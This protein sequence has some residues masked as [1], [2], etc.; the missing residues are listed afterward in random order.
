MIRRAAAAM[1]LDLGHSWLI[2]DAPRDIEAGASAGLRTIL[3]NADGVTPSPAAKAETRVQPEF[4]VTSLREALWIIAKETGKQLPAMTAEEQEMDE[5][6]EEAPPEVE[7]EDEPFTDTAGETMTE[8]EESGRATLAW[9]QRR[10]E[11]E[12][13]RDHLPSA[14]APDVTYGSPEPRDPATNDRIAQATAQILDDIRRQRETPREDFNFFRLLAGVVQVLAVA[15][16]VW[17]LVMNFNEPRLMLAIFLQLLAL[18]L[19]S[20]SAR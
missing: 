7:P 4:R 20:A 15:A 14:A 10:R 13:P 9:S 3:L 8:R 17:A 6:D 1:N 2:G 16:V 5:L 11:E 18:T 12:L 19:V